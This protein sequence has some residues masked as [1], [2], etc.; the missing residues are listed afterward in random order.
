MPRCL[1][2][3]YLLVL[4]PK[5]NKYKCAKCGKLYLQKDVENK[6]F[7]E[8][9]KERREIDKETIKVSQKKKFNESGKQT[10]LIDFE[11]KANLSKGYYWKHR[12]DILLKKRLIACVNFFP[13]E[14]SYWWKGKIE[15]SDEIVSIV[16]TKKENWNKL[17]R[18]VEKIHP[19][20]IPCIMKFD[21]EANEDY[22]K[23]INEETK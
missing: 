1:K 11:K 17:K 7:R 23:W 18:E 21:V 13:I 14:S 4:L 2:C 8:W 22:E 19:Y 9:N 3:G 6:E 10:K 20:E 15:N 5:R 16:K 12:D